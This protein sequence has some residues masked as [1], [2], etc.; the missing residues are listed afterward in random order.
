[1]LTVPTCSWTCVSVE[2]I[3][4]WCLANTGIPVKDLFRSDLCGCALHGGSVAWFGNCDWWTCSS[5]YLGEGAFHYIN[6]HAVHCD[7]YRFLVIIFARYESNEK[8]S[9][10]VGEDHFS[11]LHIESFGDSYNAFTFLHFGHSFP[12][13]FNWG[14]AYSKWNNIRFLYKRSYYYICWN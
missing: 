9:H 4:G 5:K 11:I 12:F 6:G 3:N 14:H 8:L 10:V 7:L 2:Y 1:M 13:L